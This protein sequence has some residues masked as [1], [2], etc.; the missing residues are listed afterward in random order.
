M[1]SSS[2]LREACYNLV[3]LE[4]AACRLTRLPEKLATAVPNLRVLNL[5]YNFLESVE[6]LEGLGRMK[7][8]SVIGSRLKG[9][10]TL[11]K[12]VAGMPDVEMLDFRYAIVFVHCAGG[13]V[14][15]T[16]LSLTPEPLDAGRSLL[17][18]GLLCDRYLAQVSR[19][20]MDEA[21]SCQRGSGAVTVD[22]WESI[23]ADP[24]WASGSGGEISRL[25]HSSFLIT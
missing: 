18:P 16:S 25:I 23:D 17:S 5:N 21:A 2:L 6:A 13:S 22:L 8:L 9:T 24:T 3:Y 14:R 7:K 15:Q 19:T 1:K 11:V 10:R 20:G 12:V 4:M